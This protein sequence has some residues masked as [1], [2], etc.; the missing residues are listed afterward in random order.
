MAAKY[1]CDGCDE[2]IRNHSLPKH[3]FRVNIARGETSEVHGDFDLCDGCGRSL[4]I[5]ASPH[6]WVRE[7]KR[8]A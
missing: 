3:R 6:K 4:T 5:N 7:A 8:V 1:F 2:E